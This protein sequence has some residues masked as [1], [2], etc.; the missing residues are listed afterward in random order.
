[1]RRL[2]WIIGA[3]VVVIIAVIATPYVYKAVRGGDDAPAATVSVDGAEEAI[4]DLDGTWVVV[5]GTAPNETSAGY[6]VDEILRGEPVTVVGSTDQVS[7]R[8]VVSDT[9]LESASF[10]VQ[11]AAIATDIGQRDEQARSPQ[12]LD[13]GAHPSATLTVAEPVELATV[14]SDGTTTTIPME[15]DLTIKGTTVRK[16]VEV[17]LLR[18]GEELIASGAVPVTW[19]EVGVEPP[20]LGFVTVDPTGTIDFLVSLARP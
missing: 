15:V 8:A 5:P 10:E 11:V 1:M 2:P 16:T 12:V 14:P 7:G 9:T 17:T 6:T 18:T 3:L 20:S 4:G 19:T 13:A